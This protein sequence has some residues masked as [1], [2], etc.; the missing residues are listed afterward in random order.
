M[1]PPQPNETACFARWR[2]GER[3]VG[4]DAEEPDRIATRVAQ[5]GLPGLSL[6]PVVL[7]FEVLILLKFHVTSDFLNLVS[8]CAAFVHDLVLYVSLDP[9][10]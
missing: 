4:R 10:G 9:F 5:I 1:L 6:L 8:V 7:M 3:K 2:R